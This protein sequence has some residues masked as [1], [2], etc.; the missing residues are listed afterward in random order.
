MAATP[1]VPSTG[2]TREARGR[3]LTDEVVASFGSAPDARYRE[4]MSSLVR[5]LH[6][7]ID[8]V[9]LTQAEW[10]AAIGFLTR[11]GQITDDTRQE[12][13]LLSD[14]LGA[15]MMT[16]GINAPPVGNASESTV[17]G[18][19]FV[20][21]A[22]LVAR[23]SDIAGDLPGRP[24]YVSGIVRD[25]EGS[26]LADAR[27]EVWAA[28]DEGFYDVQRPDAALAGRAQLRTDDDGGYD[29]WT[30]QPAAYPIPYDGPVG[31]LLRA[32]DRSPMRPAHIHF[33][34]VAP[35][36]QTLITHI[37]QAGDP[38]LGMDAVFGVRESLIVPF[39]DHEPGPGPGGRDLAVEWGEAR[40][41]IVL[42]HLENRS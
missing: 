4:V 25:T 26:P 21:D 38:Y 16:V 1:Q 2:L 24:F 8:D 5:H 37:F 29:F 42:A 31:D 30:V 41:D 13:I 18:P 10:D 9:S 36:F 22:P 7:F 17:V 14:V 39:V 35:G 12:F 40:F 20:A 15:S 6:S 19:F 27:V 23:G 28:D 3:S 32:A 34:V 33:M 11:C